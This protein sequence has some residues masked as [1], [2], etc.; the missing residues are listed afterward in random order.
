M[1]CVR[2][3]ALLIVQTREIEN[4]KVQ[5]RWRFYFGD[6]ARWNE[7]ECRSLIRLGGLD[8]NMSSSLI[9]SAK[10]PKPVELA[11]NLTIENGE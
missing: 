1:R 6:E 2:L 9:K 3:C 5:E 4:R 11:L 10:I 8:D 7:R